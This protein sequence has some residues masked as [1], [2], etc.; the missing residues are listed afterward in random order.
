MDAP[1]IPAAIASA[2]ASSFP[3]YCS[4]NSSAANDDV[5]L[6]PLP[7]VGN[8]ASVYTDDAVIFALLPTPVNVGYLAVR[9]NSDS[10]L[11]SV[12]L[13]ACDAWL[14]LQ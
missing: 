10:S 12:A 9:N 3:S 11:V 14:G 6:F 8:S 5:A 2:T 13:G 7:T 4:R 1:P